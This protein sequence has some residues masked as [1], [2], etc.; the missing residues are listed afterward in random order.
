MFKIESNISQIK[1][2][3]HSTMKQLIDADKILRTAAFDAVALVSD[4]VQHKGLKSDGTPIGKY[5]TKNLAF[6]GITG[7]FSV[8]ANKKQKAAR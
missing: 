1:D 3:V 2:H 6:K 8:L 5:G 7:K 4:R